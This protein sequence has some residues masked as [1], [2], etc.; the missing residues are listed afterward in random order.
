M[1]AFLAFQLLTDFTIY[2]YP[3]ILS[4]PNMN[5]YLVHVY[6]IIYITSIQWQYNNIYNINTMAIQ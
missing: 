1:A 2:V 4:F 3:D 5:L 6:T